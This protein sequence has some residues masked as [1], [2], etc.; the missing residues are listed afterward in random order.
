MKV[1]D[2]NIPDLK[3]LEP[4]CYCDDRGWF[5]ESWNQFA[6]DTLVAERKFV[7]DNHSVSHKGVLRGLHYQ[8]E[9]KGQGKLVRVVKGSAFDVA[10]DIRSGSKTYGQHFSIVLSEEN[11][12]VLWIPEGFCHG[13][14]ALEDNTNFQYKTTEVYNRSCERAFRW[15]SP[16]LGIQW[17][18]CGAL[19]ISDKDR[20]AP[21]FS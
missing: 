13:F 15:N 14:L 3:I 16:K 5:M 10:V 18:D 21:V 6:F 7:Q 4:V 11:R 12:Q 9:P 8:V 19:L 17:P 2:T 20:I 1:I